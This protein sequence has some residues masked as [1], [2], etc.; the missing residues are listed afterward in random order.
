[1]LPTQPQSLVDVRDEHGTRSS[2]AVLMSCLGFLGLQV[3]RCV[4]PVPEPS[5]CNAGDRWDCPGSSVTP[6]LTL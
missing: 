2:R 6:G 5:V 1:M 3:P 4:P